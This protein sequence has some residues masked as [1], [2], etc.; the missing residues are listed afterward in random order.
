VC[1]N[2]PTPVKV[3]PWGKAD[4]PQPWHCGCYSLA[5]TEH[6]VGANG[7]DRNDVVANYNREVDAA[8]RRADTATSA[9]RRTKAVES[10]HLSTE[11]GD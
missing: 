10:R 2:T 4:G 9:R 7:D 8:G 1:G 6:Y 11:A 3:E 5:P